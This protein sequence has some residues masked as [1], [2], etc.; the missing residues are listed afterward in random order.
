MYAEKIKQSGNKLTKPRQLVLDAL[1]ANQHP[2]SAQ[3]LHVF[4]KRKIDLASVYRTLSLFESLDIVFRERFE[5]EELFY[6]GKKQHHHIVCRKCGYTKCVP[7]NHVF[8]NIKD[9]K[10][11]VHRLNISGICNKCT[12]NN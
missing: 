3:D 7:C 6:L 4:L 2:L 9:F 12:T 11:I 1:V 10:N 5:N 8:P